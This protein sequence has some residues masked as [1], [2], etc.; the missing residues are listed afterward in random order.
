MLL[1][2][3]GFKVKEIRSSFEIKLFIMYT[4]FPIINKFK[5][6]KKASGGT[7][8]QQASTV[9]ANRQSFFNKFT[10]APKWMLRIFVFI[11]NTIYNTLSA[12]NIGEEMIVIAEKV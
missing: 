11:H 1:E 6:S 8:E 4:L 5:S 12:L 2:K 3:N 9:T 7:I 10:N